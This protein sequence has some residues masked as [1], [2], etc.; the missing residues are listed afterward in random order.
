MLKK[1]FKMIWFYHRI[2]GL[3]L[4]NDGGKSGEVSFMLGEMSFKLREVILKL[5]KWV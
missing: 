1:I 5:G 2:R 3:S 4:T